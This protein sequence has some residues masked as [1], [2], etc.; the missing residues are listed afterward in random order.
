MQLYGIYTACF[1]FAQAKRILYVYNAKRICTVCQ[2][3]SSA[4]V[5]F[6][7][8]LEVGMVLLANHGRGKDWSPEE[9][10]LE[11]VDRWFLHYDT[12]AAGN[13]DKANASED[14]LGRCTLW[15]FVATMLLITYLVA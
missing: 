7:S 4:I 11:I 14:T 10:G 13:I 8:Q 12:T 5:A 3:Y 15:L 1:R 9:I 6:N 2:R